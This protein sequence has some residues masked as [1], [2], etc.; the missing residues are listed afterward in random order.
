MLLEGLELLIYSTSSSFID[1]RSQWF[2]R[3]DCV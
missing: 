1:I 3:R 2:S